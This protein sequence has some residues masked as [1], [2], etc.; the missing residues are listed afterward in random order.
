MEYLTLLYCSIN[1]VTRY[2]FRF[3]SM[4][5]KKTTFK[6]NGKVLRIFCHVDNKN[7]SL[8]LALQIG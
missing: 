5:F 3:N 4:K 1:K 2:Y 8:K 7:C 6:L